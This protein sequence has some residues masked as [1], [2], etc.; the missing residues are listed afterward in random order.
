MG[1]CIILSAPSGGGK[2][3]IMQY[4]LNCNLGLEFSISACTRNK[5][6]T[7]IDGKDYY[8]LSV[9]EFKKRIEANEFVEWEEVYANNFYG[10]L[11]TEVE[12]I[13]TNGKHVIFDVDV[14]GGLS[15][16][17]SFGNKA[18][19]IF[20]QAPSMEALEIRL[21]S[22]K[23]ET[24]ESLQKRLKKAEYELTYANQFDV[25]LI[26]DDLK[27]ACEEAKNIA[28]EFLSK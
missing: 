1:K 5:R 7:E 17:K 21:R 11:K 20:I 15:L 24:E 22:R 19:G 28:C 27:K 14:K 6:S 23:T 9:E 2:T 10:T 13:W 8:F 12:R 4:L 18:L 3:T 16:K 26:N 25:V